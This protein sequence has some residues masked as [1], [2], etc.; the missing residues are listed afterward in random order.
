MLRH[1]S[2]SIAALCLLAVSAVAEPQWVNQQGARLV[3]GQTSFTRE[4]PASSREVMGAAGGV[5]VGGDRLFI[6]DGNRVGA[7]VGCG[8][9][10]PAG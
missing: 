10:Q 1:V 3:I 6:A 5:A 8:A 7:K 2:I 4:N 9:P